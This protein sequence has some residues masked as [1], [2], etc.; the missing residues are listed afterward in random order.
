MNVLLSGL[1][2][3]KLEDLCLLPETVKI[4]VNDY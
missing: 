3:L 2:V 4:C 1:F